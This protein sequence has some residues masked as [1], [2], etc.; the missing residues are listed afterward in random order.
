MQPGDSGL[1]RR[2]SKPEKLG[3]AVSI[4]FQIGHVLEAFGPSSAAVNAVLVAPLRRDQYE[5]QEFRQSQGH[6]RVASFGVRLQ[7][8]SPL[9]AQTAEKYVPPAP[10][11]AKSSSAMPETRCAGSTCQLQSRS[12]S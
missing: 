2:E 3:D 7:H 5:Q 9:S 8:R 11:R 12:K 6:E 10:S 1:I 4:H